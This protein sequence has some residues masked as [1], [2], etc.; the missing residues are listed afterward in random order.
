MDFFL[1]TLAEKKSERRR[2]FGASS[3]EA[4]KVSGE[5]MR[6]KGGVAPRA[7]KGKFKD[8]S[9]L[10]KEMKGVV[11]FSLFQFSREG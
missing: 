3:S 4:F 11:K 7:D 6:Q 10:A 8:Y 2:L 9:K 5:E 1:L